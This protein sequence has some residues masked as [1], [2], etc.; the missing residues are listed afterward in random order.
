MGWDGVGEETEINDFYEVAIFLDH[1]I[2][3]FSNI[4]IVLFVAFN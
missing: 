2:V 1:V 4:N 3:T